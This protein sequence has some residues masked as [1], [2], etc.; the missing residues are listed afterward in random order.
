MII[1]NKAQGNFV[2]I[3]KEILKDKRLKLKERG[4][5]ATLLSLS[6]DWTFSLRGLASI[7]PDG[8]DAIEKSFKRLIELG[9]V[10]IIPCRGE[11][12]TFAGNDIVVN[13][14]PSSVPQSEN[15]DAVRP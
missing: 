15:P 4:L 8:R 11:K 10:A 7:L 6:D 13:E 9:Y 1:K 2:M 14:L 3:S 12:G 5:L